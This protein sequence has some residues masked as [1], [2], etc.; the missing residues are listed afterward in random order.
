MH[1]INK[2]YFSFVRYTTAN[3]SPLLCEKEMQTVQRCSASYDNMEIVTRSSTREV[4]AYYK[5][6]DISI[7]LIVSLSASHPLGLI[8]VN[9]GKRVGVKINQ[10][11][12]WMMQLT[13]FLM[14][15]VSSLNGKNP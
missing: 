6:E 3:V 11:R 4:I 10:W 2:I 15:Q 1:N 5:I 9:S 7:E 12:L 14:H 8:T 13:T